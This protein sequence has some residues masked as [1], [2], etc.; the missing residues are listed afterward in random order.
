LSA[1]YNAEKE[2]MGTTMNQTTTYLIALDL[3]GTSVRYEPQLEMDPDIIR[4][5]DSVRHAGV[6]WV[7]NSDRYTDTMADIARRLSPEHMPEALLSC[8]RFI[9]ILNGDGMYEPLHAWNNEQM[10]L[11][12]DLW[13]KL[14]PKFGEW[15][16]NILRDFTVLDCVVND[17]V[18]AFMAPPEQTPQLRQRLQE[19]VKDF[20]DA[21]VSGNHDWSFILH[22]AF[23]KGRVLKRYAEH[24]GVPAERIIAVGDGV[25][26]ITMLDGSVTRLV[27]C[28]ANASFEVIAAVKAAGGMVAEAEGPQ[29]TLAILRKYLCNLPTLG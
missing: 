9:H 3:D 23:S 28:P 29:G 4:F 2:T 20:P 25:N 15:Q 26:D 16:E 21:Q 8:Q 24:I 7:M 17:L 1:C 5:L 10:R 6:V 19:Y 22:A 13:H 12:A 18:F 11:H 27:G 14:Q